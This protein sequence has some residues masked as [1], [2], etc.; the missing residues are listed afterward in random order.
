[1]MHINTILH[2]TDFSEIAAQALQVARSLARDHGAKLVLVNVPPLPPPLEHYVPPAEYPGG[3]E[4][5]KRQ[6]DHLA[7]SITDVQVEPCVHTGDPGAAI[8]E[9]ADQHHAELIVMGTHGRRGFSRL[10]MGSVAEHV[11]RN[12]HCPV[13]TIKPGVGE[14]L[15]HDEELAVDKQEF[16]PAHA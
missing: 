3:V 1:M 5:A 4:E 16:V 8:L 11:V 14:L 9:A 15:L 2:P 12:A 7:H 13:L 6:L 10:L